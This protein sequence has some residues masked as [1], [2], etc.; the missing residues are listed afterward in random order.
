MRPQRHRD[1]FRARVIRLL[2]ALALATS[3]LASLSAPPAA[4]AVTISVGPAVDIDADGTCSLLE[5]FQVVDAALSSTGVTNDCYNDPSAPTFPITIQLASGHTYTLSSN[6]YTNWNSA[7]RDSATAFPV[8]SGSSVALT[9]EGNGAT[10]ARDSAA[11][12]QF[13]FFYVRDGAQLSLEEVTLQNGY[14]PGSA[15][16]AIWASN[17]ATLTITGSTFSQNEAEYGGA[18]FAE[19]WFLTDA[20]VVVTNSTFSANSTSVSDGGSAIYLARGETASLAFVTLADHTGS[21]AL[22]VGYAEAGTFRLKNVVL[23]N[24]DVDECEEDDYLTVQLAGAVL[25][26]DSSC[27]SGVTVVSTLR[28]TLGPLADNDGPTATHALLDGSPAI[29]AVPDDQCTDWDNAA[30]TTDQR[31]E[32]RPN[33]S[34]TPC[35]A[36]AYESDRDT[37][38]GSID[39]VVTNL[40]VRQS[41]QRYCATVTVANQG[42]VAAPSTSLR[43]ALSSTSSGGT[44]VATMGVPTLDPGGTTTLSRCLS[45]PNDARRWLVA[46]VDWAN[47]VTETDET[48]N[49]RAVRFR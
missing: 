16:G 12:D 48:N 42:S 40:R 39:L 4:A 26:D 30:V 10:I 2:W 41:G 15:G 3:A 6:P 43:L 27:G 47:A 38:S 5:A 21:P 7:N 31:G 9:I 29:G 14:A 37:P 22:A 25:A 44:P 24:P 13:R 49:T 17:N 35:D 18:I 45:L 36:G 28:T 46:T 1:R 32:P 34:E 33:P 19:Q 20:T 11:S 23:A 8:L